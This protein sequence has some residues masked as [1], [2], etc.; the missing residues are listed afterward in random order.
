[1][2]LKV[3]LGCGKRDFGEGWFHVDGEAHPHVKHHDILKLPF[4]PGT[5][6]LI[7]ASHVLEYFDRFEAVPVLA[8]WRS[9]LQ[10]GGTLRL[11]VPDFQVMSRLYQEGAIG[12]Q[13]IIG[14][15]YGRMKMRDGFIYH[16]TTYDFDTL[17]ETLGTA[18]FAECR[19]YD[20]RRT[21]HAQFDDH[22]QAYIPHMDKDN[23]VLI[24]LNVEAIR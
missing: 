15:L 7:Y 4:E 19:R 24:S 6:Q 5:V 12:L 16:R 23:G 20:W 3:H 11:A 8:Q 2:A 22:S 9:Y 18:G 10:P 13:Q 1:M 17:R 21:E 14:P